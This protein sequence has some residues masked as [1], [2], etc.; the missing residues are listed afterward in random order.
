MIEHINS[1]I[2]RIE[3]DE[4]Y[5]IGQLYREDTPA[6]Y[7]KLT[8]KLIKEDRINITIIYG[9]SVFWQWSEGL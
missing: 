8:G 5:L 2:N 1:I 9:N 4:I 6:R 7:R 3:D